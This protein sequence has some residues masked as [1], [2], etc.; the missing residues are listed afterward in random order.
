M[1]QRCSARCGSCLEAER[2]LQGLRLLFSGEG[3]ALKNRLDLCLA[4]SSCSSPSGDS[5]FAN[6]HVCPRQ[7]IQQAANPGPV[8]A[9]DLLRELRRSSPCPALPLAVPDSARVVPGAEQGAAAAPPSK[10]GTAQ[11][12]IAQTACATSKA[13][14]LH[15]VLR[16]CLPCRAELSQGLL[17]AVPPGYPH[18]HSG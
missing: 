11:S 14:L 1:S 6:P 18:Q 7:D 2:S 8:P 16:G 10:A 3:I 4:A 5:K 17:R 15:G 13:L 12:R 9:R